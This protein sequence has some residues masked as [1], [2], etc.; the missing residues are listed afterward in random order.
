MENYTNNQIFY[1]FW[2]KKVGL[3]KNIGNILYNS[4]DNKEKHFEKQEGEYSVKI[5]DEEKKL[6]TLIRKTIKTIKRKA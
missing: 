2:I 6:R 4:A 1:K 5:K 3:N